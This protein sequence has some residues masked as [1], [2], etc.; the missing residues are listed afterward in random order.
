MLVIVF[1]VIGVEFS[2]QGIIVIQKKK[3]DKQKSKKS[4]KKQ[5]E[6]KKKSRSPEFYVDETIQRSSDS[7]DKVVN[8]V[9][10]SSNA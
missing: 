6:E 10:E 9:E 4:K 3:K 7:V 2:L 8:T 5:K 1:I